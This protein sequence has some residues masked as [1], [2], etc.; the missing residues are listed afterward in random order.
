VKIFI[1]NSK[2]TVTVRNKAYSYSAVSNK[3]TTPTSS[4]TKNK[5]QRF[6]S[7]HISCKVLPASSSNDGLQSQLKLTDCDM[8]VSCRFYLAR[9]TFYE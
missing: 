5:K 8:T 3:W 4:V 9:F 1:A 2:V 7:P 6:V